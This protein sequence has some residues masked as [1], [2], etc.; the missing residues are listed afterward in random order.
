MNKLLSKR[1]FTSAKSIVI[2][3]GKR[4]PIGSFMGKLSGIHASSLGSAAI[5]GAIQAAK[6]NKEEVC[7]N[8]V[9]LFVFWMRNLI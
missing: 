5:E 2:V 4:T 9:K 6:I 8:Y 1:F 7:F 3:N